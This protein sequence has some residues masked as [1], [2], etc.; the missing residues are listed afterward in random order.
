[1]ARAT[2]E[3]E[4]THFRI[5]VG[6]G[7]TVVRDGLASPGDADDSGP[8]TPRTTRRN[9]DSSTSERRVAATVPVSVEPI[10]SPVPEDVEPEGVEPEG[11]A[12]AAAAEQPELADQPDDHADEPDEPADLPTSPL[13]A[14]AF[15]ATGP[16]RA[17]L[18]H[19]LLN[20][21]D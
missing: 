19:T 4:F 15:R 9:G 3:I 7:L 18:T 11:T 10:E 6:D 2:R 13:L 17:V 8:E 16:Q 21:A 5:D 12:V 1:M 14:R 20:D